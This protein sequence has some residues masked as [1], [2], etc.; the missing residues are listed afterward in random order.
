MSKRIYTNHDLNQYLLGALPEAE[1]ESF[2]ELSFA[3]EEFVD[4]LS[5]AEKDLVDAYVH[6]DLADAELERFKS[7]YLASPLRR[8]KVKFAQAFKLMTD[9]RAVAPVGVEAAAKAPARRTASGWFSALNVFAAGHPAQQWGFVAVA[10]VLMIGAGWLVFDNVR[11]RHQVTQTQASRDELLQRE[12]ELQNQITGEQ[13]ASSTTK[14]ELARLRDEQKRLEQ[15]LTKQREQQDIGEQHQ[16]SSGGLSVAS[17]ILAPQLRGAG[18]IQ[19]ISVPAKTDLVA[20]HLGL[21]PNDYS[22]Y[23]VALLDQSGNQT[24]WRS[25]K[26]QAKGT[27][28]SKTISVS[29]RAAVLKPQTYVLRVSGISAKGAAEIVGDYPFRV[30]KSDNPR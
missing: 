25:S 12:R 19:T 1:A 6:G 17:F 26:I 10:L 21:E 15:E 11:L 3:E 29:L 2:D 13:S 5:A 30:V 8:E 28:E 23:R 7:Y 20:M 18:Q 4:A 24:L 22:A 14:Q 27:H 9:R 16:P